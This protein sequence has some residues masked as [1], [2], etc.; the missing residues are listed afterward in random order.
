MRSP[1]LIAETP[2]ANGLGPLFLAPPGRGVDATII[3]DYIRLTQDVEADI[4]EIEGEDYLAARHIVTDNQTGATAAETLLL[5][6]IDVD[7]L[8]D[9]ERDEIL[10]QLVERLEVLGDALAALDW[11]E[12]RDNPVVEMSELEEWHE[13]TWDVLPRTGAWAENRPTEEPDVSE[14][15]EDFGSPAIDESQLNL[16]FKQ[17]PAPVKVETKPEEPKPAPEPVVAP[18]PAK[19]ETPAPAPII[20]EKKPEPIKIE[21][22]KPEPVKDAPPAEVKKPEPAPIIPVPTPA[23]PEPIIAAKVE[24]AKKPEPIPVV[25]PKIEQPKKPDPAAPIVT[26]KV[27]QPKKPEPIPVVA[28]KV[29]QPKKSEQIIAAKVEPAKKP[30]PTPTPKPSL[31]DF[32]IPEFKPEPV[33]LEMRADKVEVPASLISGAKSIFETPPPAAKAI[34][35]AN[36]ISSLE[37]AKS[38]AP[39]E[40]SSIDLPIAK[41]RWANLLPQ[42]F[43]MTL[44]AVGAWKVASWSAHS[45]QEVSSTRVVV[46]QEVVYKEAPVYIDRTVEK[47]VE[48]PVEKIVEK[49]VEKPVEKIVEKFIEKSGTG[50]S[51]QDQWSQYQADYIARIKRSDVMAAADL[52]ANSKSY[53]S[54]WGMEVPP[55]LPGLQHD[56]RA[57]AKERLQQWA[58]V[59][60]RE[61]RFGD[62]YDSLRSFAADSTVQALMAPQSA[63][64]IAQQVRPAIHTAEDEFHYNRI[65]T[66]IE[67]NGTDDQVQR[68]IDA[69]LSLREPAGR[70]VLE[71]QKLSEYRQWLRQ[72]GPRN[73][74]VRVEWGPRV[75]R[76]DYQIEIDLGN[77]PDG[78]PIKRLSRSIS[79]RPG[80]VWSES[81]PLEGLGTATGSIPYRIKTSRPASPVEELAEAITVKTETFTSE[82][83]STQDST[84]VVTGT[85][86]SVDVR[87]MME[88]PTLPNWGAATAPVLPVSFPKVGQ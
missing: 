13:S 45:E 34:D 64:D 36:V 39:T 84:N 23:K 11:R 30:E 8:S 57:G 16:F 17:E 38:L 68:H 56:F 63:A 59:R 86:V 9:E 69:Y 40:E 14:S 65:K 44:G 74:V 21:A 18:A 5:V 76:R 43:L 20:I 10:D 87:N 50:S 3:S 52:L 70:M 15:V 46:A 71:V 67:S 47:V 49:V 25:A 61:H 80:E 42:A 1:V 62:A 4:T 72:G 12:I 32:E 83:R 41:R 77:G 53:L 54:T 85:K 58:M 73:A 35:P 29:E 24:P 19:V 51:K 31:L 2:F 79:A 7:R 66:L 33:K 48:K 27:E 82:G 22:P 75:S 37:Q 88:K 78:K 28:P 55:G 81:L 26:P 6:G 60:V